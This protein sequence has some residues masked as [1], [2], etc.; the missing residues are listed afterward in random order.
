[1]TEFDGKTVVITGAGR[2]IGRRLAA[3]FAAAGA[4]VVVNYATSADGAREVVEEIG[5]TGGAAMAHQADIADAAAVAGMF[6]AALDAFG[7]VDVLVNNAGLNIDKPFLELGEDDWDRVCDVNLKG[8]F[9]CSQAAGRAMVAA[10]RGRIVNISAVTAV[11]ARKNAANYCSSKAG[12]NMLT[13]CL[14]LELAP[15]VSVNCLALGFIESA[16][17][18]QV[19]SEDQLVAVVGETPLGRMGTYDEVSD[20]VRY[21]ASDSAAFITGQTVILDGGRVMR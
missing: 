18:H 3:D 17:V 10:K 8:P 9:L 19:F 15:F 6:D 20:A 14:A 1:M 11:E 21:L 13:K 7:S 5:A 4:R 12:L 16:I 2:G